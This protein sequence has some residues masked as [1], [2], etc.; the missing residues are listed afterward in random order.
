[1][2]S[3]V[4]RI[5]EPD[6]VVVHGH[7]RS[8]DEVYLPSLGGPNEPVGRPDGD[9]RGDPEPSQV[10]IRSTLEAPFQIEKMPQETDAAGLLEA[11]D[12]DQ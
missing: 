4:A 9:C 7:R 6:V 8:F 2:A 3:Q 10:S 1:M 11:S 5:E 12:D